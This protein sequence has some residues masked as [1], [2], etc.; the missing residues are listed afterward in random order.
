[1][2]HI[3]KANIA[4]AA[5]FVRLKNRM[6]MP[7]GGEETATGGFILGTNEESYQFYIAHGMAL[8]CEKEGEIVGFGIIFPD[9]MVKVSEVWHKRALATWFEEVLPELEISKVAYFEQLAFL[10]DYRRYAVELTFQ[11]MNGVFGEGHEVL[12]AT[13]VRKPVLNMAA[14]PFIRAVGGRLVGNINEDYQGMGEINSDIYMVRKG[15]YL[16]KVAGFHFADKYKNKE[17]EF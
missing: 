3:R 4:D 14:V 12:L 8:V 13:T 7:L 5:D 16:D 17:V 6:P 9:D 10:P 11:L 15:E 2:S 1:M